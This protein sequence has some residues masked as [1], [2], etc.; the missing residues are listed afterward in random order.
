M[1]LWF[2]VSNLLWLILS[3]TIRCA[4]IIPF[5]SSAGP[6]IIRLCFLLSFIT[7]VVVA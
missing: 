7:H 2:L 5:L 6:A 4:N 3:K 1:S